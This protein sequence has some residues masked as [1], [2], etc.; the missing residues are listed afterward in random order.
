MLD[1]DISTA[2]ALNHLS[3]PEAAFATGADAH[4]LDRRRFLQLVGM[5]LG[6]GLVAGPARRCSTRR[7]ATVTPRGPRVR[8]EPAMA[9]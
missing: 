6:A 5:G 1:N 4:A 7:S 2:S 8:S 3:V 9:S